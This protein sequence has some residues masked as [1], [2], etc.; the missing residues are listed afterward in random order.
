MAGYLGSLPRMALGVNTYEIHGPNVS[1]CIF[2]YASDPTVLGGL[3]EGCQQK[4]T[5][6]KTKQYF[7]F[8]VANDVKVILLCYCFLRDLLEVGSI[9]FF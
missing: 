9:A 3:S 4:M 7:V 6:T 2:V 1:R 8:S 5:V